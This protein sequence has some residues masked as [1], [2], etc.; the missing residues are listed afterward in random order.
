LNSAKRS[1]RKACSCEG[2]GA[3][4][5]ASRR[6]GLQGAF[7]GVGAAVDCCACDGVL[8]V[9]GSKR[10]V[11]GP[12]RDVSCGSS[13][14]GMLL[15]H[16]LDGGRQS[17]SRQ[18][19]MAAAPTPI[20]SWHALF[21]PLETTE[22][23]VDVGGPEREVLGEDEAESIDRVFASRQVPLQRRSFFGLATTGATELV[24][25]GSKI[26]FQRPEV[27]AFSL[28]VPF[29]STLRL[30][31]PVLDL[32]PVFRNAAHF[33][34]A[35]HNL[36]SAF[37]HD[38]LLSQ[39]AWHSLPD[40][41]IHVINLSSRPDRWHRVS[42]YPLKV[43]QCRRVPAIAGRAGLGWEGCALSH[44]GIVAAA[45]RSG[46]PYVI[47]AEDDF[48][49]TL[50]WAS[51]ERR[52]AA[53]LRWLLRHV[54]A[55]E[56][57]NGHP[58]GLLTDAPS[59]VISMEQGLVEM[60]GGLNTHF[61]IYSARSYDKVLRWCGAYGPEAL[62]KGRRP[63]AE[64]LTREH[65]QRLAIDEWI[66]ARC[67]TVTT[68]PLLTVSGWEDSDVVGSFRATDVDVAACRRD[69]EAWLQRVHPGLSLQNRHDAKW[70]EVLAPFVE[71]NTY[72]FY[73]AALTAPREAA[74]EALNGQEMRSHFTN[75][76]QVLRHFYDVWQFQKVALPLFGAQPCSSDSDV[77]VVCTSCG[78]WPCLFATLS[79]F[80]HMNSYP[81]RRI[82][83]CEDSGDARMA[84]NITRHFPMVTLL[85]DG[86]R[87][88]QR[89]R[90]R[91]LWEAAD[92]P[93]VF[94][95][96]DDW[97]F[98]AP[99]FIEQSKILLNACPRLLCTWLRD[100]N[101]TNLHPVHPQL[102]QTA[103]ILHWRMRTD[104][105]HTWH[106]FTF[107]PTLM[108]TSIVRPLL[109]APGEDEG[110]CAW[111]ASLSQQFHNLGFY[112]A[113]LPSG[114]VAHTGLHSAA[115]REAPPVSNEV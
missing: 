70:K 105:S 67:T 110:G 84:R 55:W 79:S 65:A 107:N 54:E 41:T 113:I 32:P 31:L 99:H 106:G 40:T 53:V 115:A 91:E 11:G 89:Q 25:R 78:R 16:R 37:L 56:V 59:R 48:A 81:V 29:T 9:S 49:N 101:D 17:A 27:P 19:K 82:L 33:S 42:T 44:V 2:P 38:A 6:A 85:Y 103:G 36:N 13:V 57:F 92:T 34:L 10:R 71:G 22:H 63:A 58:S 26:H 43:F 76:S 30:E 68:V 12:A 23:V 88:G 83:V 97:R 74:A 72:A 50:D 62:R 5:A 24:Y 95:M 111:E 47:V 86:A 90:V 51:W 104:Y 112:A 60:P 4:I 108:R 46:A 21:P 61:I 98:R 73:E 14:G 94:H 52:L 100:L 3:S 102:Q 18:R 77:T 1:D 20:V 96:E 39:P 66:S 28:G 35:L 45:K 109:L 15:S 69:Y 64:T 7:A 93:F 80:L 75:C 8:E 87:R 114:F